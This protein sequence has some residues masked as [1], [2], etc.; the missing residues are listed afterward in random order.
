MNKLNIYSRLNTA[1]VRL[2]GIKLNKSGHNKFAGYKYFELGD[3]LPAAQDIF[4]EVGLCGIIS[5]DETRAKMTIFNCDSP[6][7][8]IVIT[9]PMGSAGLKGCHDVQNIGAVETYQRRY[10]W[11]T[12][13]E[14]VEHDTLNR[15]DPKVHKELEVAEKLKPA[16]IAIV[17]KLSAQANFGIDKLCEAYKV[18]QLN[19]INGTK[20]EQICKG[21]QQKIDKI[22]DGHQA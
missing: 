2:Q 9:S 12:A 13:L 15:L 14:I 20:F 11:Q 22:S 7:E 3:F 5:F 21:L 6:E 4:S 17:E 19:E 1:R 18:T 16:Q 8:T 10:L